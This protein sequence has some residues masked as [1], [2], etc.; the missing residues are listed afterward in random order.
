M[1]DDIAPTYDL[2]NHVFSLGIDKIWRR[3]V[4]KILRRCGAKSILDVA[5]GTGDLAIAIAEGIP[6]SAIFGV[7]LSSQMLERAQNKILR[8][9]LCER[10][11][12][13]QCNV[14]DLALKQESLDAV[15]VAFGI[16]NFENREN[17]I[18]KFL[19]ILKPGGHLVILEF[20]TPRTRIVS[21]LYKFY[22]HHIMPLIGA[23]V[24]KNKKAYTYLPNSVDEFPEPKKFM[25]TLYG[26]GF[27]K[28]TKRS[29]SLGI[30]Q[31]YI[32]KKPA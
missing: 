7:D 1:F 22:F 15:T 23:L 9:G 26:A 30:A 10:I 6:G 28:V 5:T 27:E 29:Q 21:N 18:E 14:D 13:E 25:Q 2:L 4:V 8:C 12:L 3:R 17:A 31:I 32:A 19:R 11:S 16:R 20:S 24:S